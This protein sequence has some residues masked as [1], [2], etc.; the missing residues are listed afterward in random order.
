LGLAEVP[1]ET[2][3]QALSGGQKTRLGLA[4][5]LLSEPDLLVLDEPT[6]HLDV[7]A[8]EWLESFIA[9]YT[10]AVLVVSHDRAFLDATVGRILYLDPEQRTVRAYRGTH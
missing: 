3:V 6:N 5:L 4:S 7:D 8:L 10:G 9:N 2:R 1:R